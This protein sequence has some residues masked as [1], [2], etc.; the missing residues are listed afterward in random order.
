M[1]QALKEKV[2]QVGLL[3]QEIWQLRLLLG[4]QQVLI[5]NSRPVSADTLRQ[6]E[7]ALAH[8]AED[9]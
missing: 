3:E 5:P 2:Q 4:L 8:P 9:H 7:D 6:V 1:A